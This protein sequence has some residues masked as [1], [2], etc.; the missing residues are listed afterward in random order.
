MENNWIHTCPKSIS[1]MWNA[2]IF[3]QEDMLFWRNPGSSSLENYSCTAIYLPSYYSSKISTGHCCRSKN[4]HI[5]DI[6]PWITTYGHISKTLHSSALCKHL[7]PSRGL[8][9]RDNRKGQML[10]LDQRYL[11]WQLNL[12]MMMMMM[13]MFHSMYFF[14]CHSFLLWSFTK[15]HHVDN[16]N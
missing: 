11:S 8:T 2:I 3:V 13:M 10:T 16:E 9:K 1:A 7:M 12:I 5:S 15:L 6:L 14:L 4:E